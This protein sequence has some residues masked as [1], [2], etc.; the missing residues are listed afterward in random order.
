M[1]SLVRK[2]GQAGCQVNHMVY[3]NGLVTSIDLSHSIKY[4]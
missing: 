2:A 3:K 4:N 1:D